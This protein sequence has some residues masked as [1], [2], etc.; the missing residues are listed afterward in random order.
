MRQYCLKRRCWFC[1][2]DPRRASAPAALEF[3]DTAFRGHNFQDGNGADDP[4][5]QDGKDGLCSAPPIIYAPSL[6]RKK[7]WSLPPLQFSSSNLENPLSNMQFSNPVAADDALPK[8][9]GF[10]HD[11]RHHTASVVTRR[12]VKGEG[13]QT[14]LEPTPG[15]C[16][17]KSLFSLL[18]FLKL[19]HIGVPMDHRPLFRSAVMASKTPMGAKHHI[20][21]VTEVWM[22]T[23]AIIL[24]GIVGLLSLFAETRA[25]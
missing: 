6:E 21:R 11:K 15:V 25:R 24:G 20:M 9:V 17:A 12:A 16:S 19:S 18:K 8:G 2:P 4:I 10:G 23:G 3:R 1:N 22:L 14:H 7:L 13:E 5:F